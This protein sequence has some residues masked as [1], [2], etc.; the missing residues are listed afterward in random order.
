[1]RP[2]A[3]VSAGTQVHT[4]SL[5]TGKA[6]PKVALTTVRKIA[7]LGE[8]AFIPGVAAVASI[9]HGALLKARDDLKAI[10]NEIEALRTSHQASI[11]QLQLQIKEVETQVSA[12]ESTTSQ[13]QIQSQNSTLENEL[14]VRIYELEL[15]VLETRE[16]IEVHA[17]RHEKELAKSNL[18]HSKAVTDLELR[19]R[20]ELKK[21]ELTYQE[22]VKQWEADKRTIEGNYAASLESALNAA[23]EEAA[24]SRKQ[25]L[26]ALEESNRKAIDDLNEKISKVLTEANEAHERSAA[27]AAQDIE[28]LQSELAGQEDKYAAQVR[29]VKVEQDKLVKDAYHRAKDEA[30]TR[31]SK[32]LDDMKTTTQLT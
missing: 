22:A 19:H 11:E 32:E 14:K 20:E 5:A 2:K 17:D 12:A 16:A 13:L 3:T 30:D 15:E 25:A 23:R 4:T 29:Q 27:L 10:R 21:A 1:M 26:A 18:S 8:Q 28:R 9:E 24:E 31:Y 7:K 6:D